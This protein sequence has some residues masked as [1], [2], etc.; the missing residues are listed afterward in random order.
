MGS[1]LCNC[2]GVGGAGGRDGGSC[3]RACS[4]NDGRRQLYRARRVGLL[5]LPNELVQ[6]V[7]VLL[8]THDLLAVACSCRSLRA[9]TTASVVGA[10]L[11]WAT[12]K[13]A[14]LALNEP[15]DPPWTTWLPMRSLVAAAA[16]RRG[17]G[18]RYNR[19]PAA[20]HLGLCASHVPAVLRL[21]GA[22]RPHRLG[23]TVFPT[24]LPRFTK[25]IPVVPRALVEG[26]LQL[27]ERLA[28]RGQLTADA[29]TVDQLMRSGGLPT[30]LR[31]LSVSGEATA[32]AAIAGP[33][34]N[35]LALAEPPVE[36]LS[37]RNS[38]GP[39]I[40][41]LYMQSTGIL[42]EEPPD[43]VASWFEPAP[44]GLRRLTLFNIVITPEAVASLAGLEHLRDLS[45]AWCI[46][47]N[48]S[49]ALLG[50]PALP[51]LAAASLF[52]V[53]P[54]GVTHGT[55]FGVPMFLKQRELDALRL[56]Q[57]PVGKAENSV[58]QLAAL[59][60][61]LMFSVSP[62][63]AGVPPCP[64]NTGVLAQNSIRGALAVIRLAVADAGAT[65]AV[66]G[67]GFFPALIDVQLHIQGDG[68][69]VGCWPDRLRLEC[70]GLTGEEPAQA[71]IEALVRAVGDAPAL[72]ESLQLLRITTAALVPA[73]AAAGLKSLTAL[74]QVEVVVPLPA[75]A[76]ATDRAAR[77]A[78]LNKLAAGLRAG[79]TA[80]FG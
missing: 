32:L 43:T 70:L 77:R 34:A 66:L 35:F 53:C 65:L 39:P 23:I 3:S 50:L 41:D 76:S 11:D 29:W 7:L 8:P 47:Q 44:R 15:G 16:T 30:G 48:D 75:A 79:A 80:V 2:N 4:D 26:T 58:A 52:L 69:A 21:L 33:V 45:L 9:A 1:G 36:A 22:T 61:C 51:C 5:D 72:A 27:A 78:Y 59:P 14:T 54:E 17:A 64:M 67:G 28:P 62:P 24:W 57:L 60:R 18:Q 63:R 38:S 49:L 71:A 6:Q 37:L 12:A 13:E 55:D 42:I 74:R 31:G 40:L 19:P 25:S 68:G 10:R 20:D 46:V 56:P 73:D